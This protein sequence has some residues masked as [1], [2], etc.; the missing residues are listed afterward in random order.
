M[1]KY[2][3]PRDSGKTLGLKETI[4]GT[5]TGDR[6]LLVSLLVLSLSGIFFIKEFIPHA[7][8]VMIEVD[9]KVTHRYQMDTDRVVK[10]DGSHGHLTVEIKD[11]KV[12]VI[13]ASCPNR[14]CERQGWIRNGAIICIPGRITVTVGAPDDPRGRTIDAVTG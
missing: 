2:S 10:V 8:G 6:I 11:R 5:T 1:G 13:D 14:I 12:R 7:Q 4:N 9:G 3:R